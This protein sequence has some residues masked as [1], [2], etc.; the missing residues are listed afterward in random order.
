MWIYLS[1]RS[2][3]CLCPS[4]FESSIDEYL[5]SDLDR[6]YRWELSY[7]VA[8]IYLL[9]FFSSLLWVIMFASLRFSTICFKRIVFLLGLRNKLLWCCH[10]NLLIS[11]SGCN[12]YTES[13]AHPAHLTDE[14]SHFTSTQPLHNRFM[15]LLKVCIGIR[16]MY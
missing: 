6:R 1:I 12:L 16:V 14:K 13:S 10:T 5:C 3:L 8:L 2:V 11:Y 9:S 15:L 4:A 7:S